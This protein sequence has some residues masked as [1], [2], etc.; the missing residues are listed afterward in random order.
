VTLSGSN[1]RYICD[2]W[3]ISFNYFKSQRSSF[4][5]FIFEIEGLDGST[6]H[7]YQWWLKVNMDAKSYKMSNDSLSLSLSLSLPQKNKLRY[8]LNLKWLIN[9]E[10]I[11][12]LLC[13]MWVFS[14]CTYLQAVSY[15]TPFKKY[16]GPSGLWGHSSWSHLYLSGIWQCLLL[17]W[18]TKLARVAMKSHCMLKIWTSF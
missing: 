17:R 16:V 1:F 7:M 8:L 6:P 2:L 5:I 10:H 4:S 12:Q 3:N 13:N 15:T 9:F 18:D 11:V 14:V